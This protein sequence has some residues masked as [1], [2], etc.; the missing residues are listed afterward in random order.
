MSAIT[1]R[2]V[3]LATL[4]SIL[5]MSTG[6]TEAPVVAEPPPPKVTVAHPQVREL[7]DYEEY[8]GWMAASDEVEIRSRV[9]GHIM[10]I[11]FTD[12]EFVEAGKLL[13]ELDPL[14]FEAEI[15]RAKGQLAVAEASQEQAKREEERYESLWKQQAATEQEYTRHQAIRKTWDAQVATAADEVK[16]RE[17]DLEYSRITAPISGKISRALLKVGDLVNAGGGDPLL[18]TIVSIDPINVY[19][20]VD[21]PSLIRFRRQRA[22][23]EGDQ[24]KP[25]EQSEIPFEF[26]MELDEGFPHKG[27]LDFANNRID[28]ETGTIE[29]RGKADNPNGLYIPGSRCRV[30]IA[31]GKPYEGVLVPDTAILTDLDQK[32][33]LCLNDENIVT[34][35]DVKLGQLLED[36]LRVVSPAK[37]DEQPLTP[38]DRVIVLG[39]QRARLNY[40][41]EPMDAEG[42]ALAKSD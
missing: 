18:T 16:R 19:F 7:T 39:L 28:A 32:Y 34:R 26:A 23:A 36:G 4:G 41:V 1:R 37:S 33:L 25:L 2:C 8:N 40:P 21:S 6:C 42:Q 27:V 20:N 17:L 5:V 11:D 24:V 3:V 15:G 31:I 30:R 14:P 22:L 13:F 9:R 12:G 29:V 35:R 10:K 38:E